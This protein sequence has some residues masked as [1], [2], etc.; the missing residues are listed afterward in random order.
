MKKRLFKISKETSN[1]SLALLKNSRDLIYKQI[2][3]PLR[4][5]KEVMK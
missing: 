1:M 4:F 5:A 3:N 2:Y